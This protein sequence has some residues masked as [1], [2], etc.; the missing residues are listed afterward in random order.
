MNSHDTRPDPQL[1]E[2]EAPPATVDLTRRRL[3]I[4]IAS[5][6]L[7]APALPGHVRATGDVVSKQHFR[8]LCIYL[9]AFRQLDESM[10]QQIYDTLLHEPW[11]REHIR[12]LLNKLF[13]D[14][15]HSA[16]PR[17]PYFVVRNL[18]DA[19]R[20]FAGHILTTWMTG[21]YYHETGN[22]TISYE[23]ALMYESLK[24]IRPVPG[25]SRESFGFWQHPPHTENTEPADG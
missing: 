3:S 4:A 19:E 8:T 5:L 2:H 17:T 25:M 14:I 9:T 18:D 10:L 20:W 11:G 16:K 12:R 23:H 22:R 1:M 7:A 6:L 15:E 21:I 24:D 13:P